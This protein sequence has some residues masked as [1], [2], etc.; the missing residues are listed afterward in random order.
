M[1]G[2]CHLQ[3]GIYLSHHCLT[4]VG[5]PEWQSI[6]EST[7]D[8]PIY[9][10]PGA[11]PPE[12]IPD[13]ETMDPQQPDLKC[14]PDLTEP[15]AHSQE[16]RVFNAGEKAYGK[17]TGLYNTHRKYSEQWN[18]CHPSQSAHNFQQLQLFRQQPKAWIAHHLM[19]EQDNF[20]IESFESVD[21]LRKF[22][23]ELNF[24]L[25]NDSWIEDHS[26]IFGTL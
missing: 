24:G 9:S 15:Q 17:A 2:L 12:D 6:S 16:V 25:S 1:M 22:L 3:A 18:A 21:A 20:K 5:T 4:S 10:E 14:T 8:L 7:N 13:N 23:P 11:T 19:S 26:H